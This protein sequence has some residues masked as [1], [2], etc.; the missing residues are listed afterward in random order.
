[1]G[2]E[3]HRATGEAKR[4]VKARPVTGPSHEAGIA[5]YLGAQ[6]YREQQAHQETATTPDVAAVQENEQPA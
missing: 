1:M 5:R 4:R 6:H 2:E 3:Q